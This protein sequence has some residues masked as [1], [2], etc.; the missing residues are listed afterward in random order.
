MGYEQQIIDNANA[1]KAILANAKKINQL[2][3]MTGELRAE[4][5]VAISIKST[6]QTVKITADKLTALALSNNAI[7]TNTKLANMAT[8]TYKGRTSAGTGVPEDITAEVLKADLLLNNV[9]NTSD[10]NKP[11][12]TA[13]KAA[14]D[15]KVD[16]NANIVAGTKTKITYD[17]KGLV[18]NG[19]DATTAD[20]ADSL[21]KR[22]VTD[23]DLVDIGNLS[24]VNTGDQDLSGYEL[25]SN[26]QNSLVVDGNGIKYPTVDAVNAGIAGINTDKV[27]YTGAT[28]NVN[29]GSNNLTASNLTGNYVYANVLLQLPNLGYITVNGN[30]ADYFKGTRGQQWTSDIKIKYA[31]DL[32]GSYDSRTLID[33][34]YLDTRLGSTGT[35]F[36]LTS[37]KVTSLSG[38]STDVQYPSA[39]LTYDQLALK[40]D[41][42]TAI[43]GATKTKITYDSKGL[44]TAGADAGISDITGLQGA[45]DNKLETSLKGVAN[46]LAEL[47]ASG[48]VK[49]TQLPSYVDDVL[50]YANL[51]SFPVTGESG[52]IYIAIDTNKTYRWSGST[53]AV[54]SE[55]IAL[56]ETDSTAYRGDRGKLAYDH[57]QLTHDKTF[58]GLGNVDNT[59]DVNKPVSTAQQTAL[60]LKVDK[61]TGSS[62]IA[63]TEITRLLGLSNYTHPAS[64]PPSIITQDASN[65]FV[66]DEEKII[67]NAK[68]GGTGTTN[69]IPKF[70]GTGSLGNSAIFESGGNVLIGTTTDNGAKLQVNGAATFSGSVTA[71]NGNFTNNN[72]TGGGQLI[73]TNLN[74]AD[75]GKTADVI[76][77]LTD[78]VGTIKNSAF[79]KSIPDI[80]NVNTGAHLVFYTRKGDVEPTESLRIDNTGAATFA[81]SVS[82]VEFI[83][84]SDL[85]L[86]ENIAILP[87]KRINSVY[88]SFNM[89]GNE[90]VR[91]GVIAQELEVENPEFVR[92]DEK[93]IKSVSYTDLHS[94]EIAYL[95]DKIKKLEELVNKLIK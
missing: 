42:N 57:S 26:K 37:N 28:T 16:K 60:N 72:A 66:T 79:I 19:E 17:V 8:K 48:F 86:K 52:K 32:S 91:V 30:E 40:V 25:L 10:V 11:V 95:K 41:K 82:A 22:Y 54:I 18:T 81:G 85:R 1:I 36:E 33:K 80:I 46:G 56:G 23:A 58:V 34:G 71:T 68:I 64:H 50:E 7:I 59:S 93:G 55:T 15:L 53:Y 67:W 38:L 94:C 44:V 65:R 24:G 2:P 39:K 83:G 74:V 90:Q 88:K 70:I 6:G 69:Y 76:F 45:L 43:T 92:T 4:D 21:N 51:A 35:G 77:K 13:Q 87:P 75:T 61:V 49:N 78:S 73:I 62:L 20:I 63:D 14:L 47:D 12:S 27:P 9:D 3:V 31:T 29:L 89:I 5:E 84:T